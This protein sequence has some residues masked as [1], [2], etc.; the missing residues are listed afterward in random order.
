MA[1]FNSFLKYG[2]LVVLFFFSALMPSEA[3][4]TRTAGVNYT[5]NYYNVTGGS[6]SGIYNATDISTNA[7]LGIIGVNISYIQRRVSSSCIA[8]SSIRAIAQDGTVTCE[9]DDLGAGGGGPWNETDPSLNTSTT[10][11]GANTSF[12]TAKSIL[13]LFCRQLYQSNRTKWYSH[14]R[15]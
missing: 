13:F 6:G 10:I 4:I 14:M 15:K 11:L 12:L 8:G 9:T 5:I 2:V 7:T 1:K 3:L